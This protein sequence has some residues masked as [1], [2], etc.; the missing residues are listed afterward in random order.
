MEEHEEN[1]SGLPPIQER[2]YL[3]E[4]FAELHRRSVEVIVASAVHANDPP[5]N[6]QTQ[7][8][9]F[10]MSYNPKCGGNPSTA[11]ILKSAVVDTEPP[12]FLGLPI[13]VNFKLVRPIIAELDSE[14]PDYGGAVICLCE[15]ALFLIK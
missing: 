1:T 15:T 5:I 12:A 7:Y 10:N 13:S 4:D 9:V 8:L 11:F 6:L 3:L 14:H 2:K